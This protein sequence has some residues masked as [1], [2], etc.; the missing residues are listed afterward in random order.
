MD[1]KEKL[2]GALSPQELKMLYRSFDLIGDIAILKIPKGL[3][4]KSELIAQAVM[5]INK[6]VKTVLRQTSPISGEYR[7]RELTWLCGERRTETIHKEHGCI[8]KVD[9]AKCY[10]SP[11]LLY[12]RIRIARQV[13]HGEVIVN[14]FAGVGCFS[15][16]IAR[17]SKP[18]K[19]YSIDINPEAV[20]YMKTNIILNKV[21]D[22]VEAI[23]G[24]SKD[25]IISRLRGIADRV[26]MPLPEKAYE[27]LDYALMAL[28]PSGGIIHYYDF[29]HAGRGED[30]I[31]KVIGK[32]SR[33]LSSM[34]VKFSIPFFRVV[35]TV[36][37]RW[38]QIVLDIF[39]SAAN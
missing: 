15:I 39:I 36:G 3:E 5:Q 4:D 10:F 28:K 19:V 30:P 24:D 34:N 18:K 7:L 2:S 16:I 11:R 29:E 31:I 33:K 13:K 12:E 8:F 14:M 38:Y 1:L 27:Y 6:H 21:E 25:I 37:P 35:R 22:I 32:V 17:H 23:E 20:K 9:L 26:L